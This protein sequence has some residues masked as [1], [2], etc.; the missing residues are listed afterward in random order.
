MMKKIRTANSREPQPR[1]AIHSN[2][3][4]S[5]LVVMRTDAARFRRFSPRLKLEMGVYL[6][7]QRREQA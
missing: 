6:D 7:L 4:E 3:F 5:L 2:Y 1:K